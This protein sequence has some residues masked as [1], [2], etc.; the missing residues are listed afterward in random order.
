[1]TP[2]KVVMKKTQNQRKHQ[3]VDTE[4]DEEDLLLIVQIAERS[5][6]N[7]SLELSDEFDISIGEL[8]KLK[9]RLTKH[10]DEEIY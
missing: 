4:F 6:V 7:W 2:K 9:V 5:I 1:M 8:G 10:L 3:G